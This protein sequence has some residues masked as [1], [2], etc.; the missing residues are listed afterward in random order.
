MSVKITRIVSVRDGFDI[1]ATLESDG[2]SQP[3]TFFWLA[4]EQPKPDDKALLIKL[5]ELLKKFINE[6]E[7]IPEV[8]IMKSEIENALFE[9]GYL[10]KG[11]MLEDLKTFDE[12][13][14]AKEVK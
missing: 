4:K 10:E 9:K 11:Q 13:L 2:K 1:T 14:L 5:D 6:P 7:P 12:L 3:I 8:T